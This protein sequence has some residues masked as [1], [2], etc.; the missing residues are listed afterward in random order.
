ML[1]GTEKFQAFDAQPIRELLMQLE[2]MRLA[3]PA[4]MNVLESQI[5]KTIQSMGGD[6]LCEPL[7]NQ[8][9]DWA[10]AELLPWI[11]EVLQTDGDAATSHK[12]KEVLSYRVVEVSILSVS[13][14]YKVDV[15]I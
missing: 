7:L 2:W 3:E 10:C 11:D 8:V 12:W 5:R 15:L 1:S 14:E 13:L 4:M 9:E 6:E